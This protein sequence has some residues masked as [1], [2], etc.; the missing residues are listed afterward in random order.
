MKLAGEHVLDGQ[1]HQE[2][3]AADAAEQDEPRAARGQVAQGAYRARDG[4]TAAGGGRRRGGATPLISLDCRGWGGRGGARFAADDPGRRTRPDVVSA[5]APEDSVAVTSVAIVSLGGI[6]PTARWADLRAVL[7]TP[8]CSAL[9][10]YTVGADYISSP[11]S[12]KMSGVLIKSRQETRCAMIKQ[13]IPHHHSTLA[14]LNPRCAASAQS[15][16]RLRRRGRSR[17]ALGR[18]GMLAPRAIALAPQVTND[19]DR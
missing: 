2:D 3:G 8:G 16:V 12:D 10:W 14:S 7:L 18:P 15:A 13:R 5:V 11:P 17:A 9:R 6:E 19:K 1:A 4:R